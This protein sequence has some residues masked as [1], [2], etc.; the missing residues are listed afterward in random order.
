MCFYKTYVVDWMTHFFFCLDGTAL[1][2]VPPETLDANLD[3]DK[4]D[5]EEDEEEE[6]FYRDLYEDET[7]THALAEDGTELLDVPPESLD[8]SINI[9]DEEDEEDEEEESFYKELYE[10][11]IQEEETVN[12]TPEQDSF[13]MASDEEDDDDSQ[14]EIPVVEEEETCTDIDSWF[15]ADGEQYNCAWYSALHSRC[16]V[17]GDR[18][19]HDGMTANEACCACGGGSR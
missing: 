7:T 15:D 6:A 13:E 12:E 10:E 8:G 17:Y 11:P 4:D 18:K 3:I 5:E 1:L 16:M 14:D 9:E 19:R 2:D